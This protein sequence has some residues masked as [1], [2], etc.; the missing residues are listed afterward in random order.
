M[1]DPIPPRVL[2]VMAERIRNIH[3]IQTEIV[4]SYT[5]DGHGPPLLVILSNYSPRKYRYRNRDVYH[6]EEIPAPGGR[7]F[8]LHRTEDAVTSDPDHEERYGVFITNAQ[9]TTCE[10]KGH[11][12]HGRCKHV[13]A[14][15]ALLAAGHIDH[16]GNRPEP[17]TPDDAPF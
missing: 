5:D 16:P 12:A 11:A 8:L 13:D 17:V 15:A 4:T 1:P 2:A 7:A 6:V 14:L 3:A 9:D 10:C